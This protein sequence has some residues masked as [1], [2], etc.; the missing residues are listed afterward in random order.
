MK[1]SRRQELGDYVGNGHL[2]QAIEGK[3]LSDDAMQLLVDV[4]MRYCEPRRKRR[5]ANR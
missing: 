2:R 4:V 1:K 3:G 5:S